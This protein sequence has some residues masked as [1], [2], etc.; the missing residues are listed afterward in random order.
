MAAHFSYYL[1]RTRYLLELR[2]GAATVLRS[3][4]EGNAATEGV[5]RREAAA[6]SVRRFE[7]SSFTDSLKE[8]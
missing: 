2:R 5:S 3:G 6:A 8:F 7:G 4:A 1:S